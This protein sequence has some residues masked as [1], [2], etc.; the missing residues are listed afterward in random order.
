LRV[1]CHVCASAGLTIE[2][3]SGRHWSLKHFFQ[4]QRLRAELDFVTPIWFRTPAFVFDWK[5]LHYTFRRRTKLDYISPTNQP[6]P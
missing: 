1:E 2:D 6:A 4:T 5:S 3:R